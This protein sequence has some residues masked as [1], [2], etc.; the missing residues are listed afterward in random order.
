M[1][2]SDR[3]LDPLIQAAQAARE[4]AYVPYSRYPVGAAVLTEDGHIVT[5]CNIEN[6]SYPLT[7][8]AE[9]VALF[10][11]VAQ[12]HRRFRALAVVTSN[13]GSPCGSCRQVMREFAP[14]MTVIIADT[15]GNRRLTTVADLL[16]DSF[17]PEHLPTG[18]GGGGA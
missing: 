4:R 13:G 12:G 14:T 1:N 9:R 7:C 6:A 11:A 3:D 5:G 17:G 8:C 16:P 15:A 10:A 2:A 18:S